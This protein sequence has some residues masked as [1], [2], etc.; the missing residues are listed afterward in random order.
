MFQYMSLMNPL[1]DLNLSDKS[2]K[3]V[4]MIGEDGTFTVSATRRWIDDIILSNSGSETRWNTSLPRK[5]NI[6]IWRVLRDK[7]P[8]SFNL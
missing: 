6:L 2:D 1:S 5:V 4:W 8:T 7:L 3:W